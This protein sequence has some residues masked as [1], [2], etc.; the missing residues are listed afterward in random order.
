MSSEISA[1]W[2]RKLAN[3]NFEDDAFT[4]HITY[5]NKEEQENGRLFP[6][7]HERAGNHALLF[8]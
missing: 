8:K 4:V 6:S 3:T 7:R 2:I 1:E 5:S